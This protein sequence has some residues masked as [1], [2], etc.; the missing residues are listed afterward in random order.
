MIYRFILVKY[1][2]NNNTWSDAFDTGNMLALEQEQGNS[3]IVIDKTKG[4]KRVI[5]EIDFNLTPSIGFYASLIAS[6]AA[7]TFVIKQ[8]CFI[9]EPTS[10]IV[11]LIEDLPVS[12]GTDIQSGYA[13]IDS[14]TYNVKVKN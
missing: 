11:S 4:S 5:M 7:P 3:I 1:D 13:Y 10:S 9:A 12:D 8:E 2:E 6:G 14:T